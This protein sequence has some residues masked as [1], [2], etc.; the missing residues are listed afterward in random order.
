MTR[1]M[2]LDLSMAKTGI[3]LPTGQMFTLSTGISQGDGRL[4]RIRAGLRYYLDACRPDVCAVEKVP[5][6][7]KGFEVAVSLI[8]VHGV[9]R[10]L[11]ADMG[12]PFAYLPASTLKK[13][14][15]GDG[16][17]GKHAMVDACR[18]LDAKPA[19]DNEADAWWLRQAG[20]CHYDRKV[21]SPAHALARELITGQTSRALHYVGKRSVKGWPDLG[22]VAAQSTR[23]GRLS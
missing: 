3:C 5:T 1:V 8:M 2:G 17:A 9:C 6:A 14:A 18:D 13:W 22:D 23:R 11:L 21:L 16:A 4:C 20:L 10:E 7:G 15:T 12:I 19:D